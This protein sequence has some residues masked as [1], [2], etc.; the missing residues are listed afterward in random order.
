M[1]EA[2]P[3]TSTGNE[4]NVLGEY[5]QNKNIHGVDPGF[6]V[7]EAAIFFMKFS[8]KIIHPDPWIHH[9]NILTYG[10]RGM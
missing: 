1:A 8:T 9:C 2:Y 3:S 10:V 4:G 7:R 6:L 5:I